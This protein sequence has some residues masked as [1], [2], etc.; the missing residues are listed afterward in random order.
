MTYKFNRVYKTIAIFVC[1]GTE[2]YTHRTRIHI[3]KISVLSTKKS[4]RPGYFSRIKK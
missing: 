3:Y 2:L 1:D 4:N